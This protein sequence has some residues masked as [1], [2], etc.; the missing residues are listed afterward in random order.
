[1]QRTNYRQDF[2]SLFF[3]PQHLRSD[4]LPISTRPLPTVDKQ[5]PCLYFQQIVILAVCLSLYYQAD[6]TSQNKVTTS[7]RHRSCSSNHLLDTTASSLPY[8]SR[9]AHLLLVIPVFTYQTFCAS[10]NGL[11][12]PQNRG[13]DYQLH[14]QRPSLSSYD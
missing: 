11:V 14:V 2:L 5:R 3:Q 12:P 10:R 9:F 8:E 7:A 13:S 1:M 4:A 6:G